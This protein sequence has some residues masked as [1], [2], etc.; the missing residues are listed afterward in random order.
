LAPP[1]SLSFYLSKFSSFLFSSSIST[2]PFP[3]L[4]TSPWPASLSLFLP[5]LF[6]PALSSLFSGA[7]CHARAPILFSAPLLCSQ[8]L[9][10][11]CQRLRTWY[12][13]LPLVHHP[14]YGVSGLTQPEAHPGSHQSTGTLAGGRLSPTP[15]FPYTHRPTDSFFKNWFWGK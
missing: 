7:K 3:L 12:L 6:S 8:L 11:G 9:Y 15:L 4:S 2:F 13:W 1:C 5:F 14:L 10:H